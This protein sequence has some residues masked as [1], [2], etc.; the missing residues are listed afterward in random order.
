MSKATITVEGFVT[1]DPEI[2]QAAGK[3][4]VSIDVAHTPRKKD[5]DQWVDAGD[6]IW[7]QAAFWDRDAQ[8]VAEAIVKGTLVTITGMPEINAYTKQDGSS[9]VSIRI[10]GATIGIIPR[11]PRENHG[12]QGWAQQPSAPQQPAQGQ[13]GAQG[14]DAWGGGDPNAHLPF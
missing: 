13:Y 14:A 4:V 9:G 5:G 8:P 2:R 10:K 11:A 3:P 12:Q 7:F 6:T 1:K